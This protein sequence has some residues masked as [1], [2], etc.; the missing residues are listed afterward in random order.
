MN[1]LVDNDILIKGS[2]YDLLDMLLAPS[3]LS[4]SSIGVLGTARYIVSSAVQEMTLMEDKAVALSRVRSSL[5]RV[6]II[7]PSEAEQLMAAELELAA[8]HCGVQ[9]DS[10]ES[11]LC[12]VVITRSLPILLTGDKRAIHAIGT[13]MNVDFRL[14]YMFKRVQCL[15]QLI[16]TAIDA[17]HGNSLRVAVCRER[18]IDKTLSICFHCNNPSFDERTTRDCL[19]SYID[20][21]RASDGHVLAP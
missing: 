5:D 7:E 14:C 8:Q 13:L 6:V 9:L 4:I 21:L 3:S 16:L 17:G 2:C 12:A 15:E 18:N 11:Q 10:G 1:A 19:L 20:D